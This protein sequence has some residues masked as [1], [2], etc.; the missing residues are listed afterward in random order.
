MTKYREILRL[1]SLG[2]SKT[3][4]AESC[5]CSRKTVRTIIARASEAEIC[6]P[7]SQDVTDADLEKKLFPKT[8]A[9]SVRKYPDLDYLHKEL[10]RDGVTLKLLWNEYCA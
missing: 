1:N 5:E 8:S 3:S 4:I 6:W 10:M 2:I 7:L 9:E